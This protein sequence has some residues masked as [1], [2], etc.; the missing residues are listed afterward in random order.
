MRTTEPTDR[1]AARVRLARLPQIRHWILWP[2]I[3][4]SVVVGVGLTLK[5]VRALTVAELGVDQAA[6]ASHTATLTVVALGLN[7]LFTPV[8]GMIL[9]AIVCLIL[10]V[11]RRSPVNAAAVAGIT[12]AGWLSS[13]IVKAIVARHRPNGTLLAHPLVTERG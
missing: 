12:L 8:G 4:A 3:L 6:S 11:A 13:E 9:L 2:A 1:V 7:A 5:S 10:L